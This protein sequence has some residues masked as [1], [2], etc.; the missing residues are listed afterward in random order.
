MNLSLD[1]ISLIEFYEFH[2]NFFFNFKFKAQFISGGGMMRLGD[3]DKIVRG[4][5]CSNLEL[6]NN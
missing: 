6:L 5:L 4:C 3:I 2:F 1:E